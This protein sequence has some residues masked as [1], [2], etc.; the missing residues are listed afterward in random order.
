MLVT[1]LMASMV[2]QLAN[3][4]ESTAFPSIESFSPSGAGGLAKLL[5][6][7][8]Y[9]VRLDRDSIPK[10]TTSDIP[11][12]FDSG[13]DVDRSPLTGKNKGGEVEKSWGKQESAQR[14]G[15]RLLA[16]I[17]GGGKAI[18]IGYKPEFEEAMAKSTTSKVVF[19]GHI[20]QVFGVTSTNRA[21]E[22]FPLVFGRD[23]KPVTRD[24]K[25]TTEPSR[26]LLDVVLVDGATI[27]SFADGLFMTNHFIA[28]EDNA[29]FALEAF[30]RI[31][32]NGSSLVFTE[33]AIGNAAPFGLLESL[34]PFTPWVKAQFYLFVTVLVFCGAI[35]FGLPIVQRDRE[36]SAREMVDAMGANL[37][38]IKQP[39]FSLKLLVADGY[40]RVRLALKLPVAASE[41]SLRKAMPDDLE[42]A[43]VHAAEV[44][45]APRIGLFSR[46]GEGRRIL[47]AAQNLESAL[48]R[49]EGDTRRRRV[50]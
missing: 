12:V 2:Y 6:A 36:R 34:G 14:L 32:P 3:R 13:E 43:L 33:A 20:D 50:G 10:L 24:S 8:G 19:S 9:S 1:L 15:A 39:A 31:A 30:H 40:E 28:K 27:Y 11:V 29:A 16:H 41:E 38:R 4:A 46:N 17:K 35:R 5:Q 26:V 37:A 25:D 18:F 44:S 45:D 21:T 23:P 42:S 49:L 48:L 47:T 22:T 7:E